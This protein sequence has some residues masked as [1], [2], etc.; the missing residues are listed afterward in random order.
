VGVTKLEDFRF[1]DLRHTAKTW[2]MKRGIKTEVSM[3]MAGHAS[4]QSHYR[5]V[6]LNDLDIYNAVADSTNDQQSA[7][8]SAT[9]QLG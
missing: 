1:K 2:L 6:N 9:E 4:V 7:T 8:K 5:Y 3:A